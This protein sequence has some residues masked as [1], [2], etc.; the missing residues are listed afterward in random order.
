MLNEFAKEWVAA[1]RSGEFKQG[2]YSLRTGD[3]KYCCLGVG[4]ELAARSGVIDPPT[5]NYTQDNY[6]YGNSNGFLP[7]EVQKHLGMSSPAGS[8]NLGDRKCGLYDDNDTILMT[9]AEIADI[10]ESE[11]AGLFRS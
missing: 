11:P 4:C 3:D 1:L 8:Y 5:R 9:F 10:I 7:A 6:V 2:R